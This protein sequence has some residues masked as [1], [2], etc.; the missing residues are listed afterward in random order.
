M[1]YK[2]SYNFPLNAYDF[3]CARCKCKREFLPGLLFAVCCN[4]TYHRVGVSG[5]I[6]V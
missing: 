1:A 4:I 3:R 6:K 2:N 5:R